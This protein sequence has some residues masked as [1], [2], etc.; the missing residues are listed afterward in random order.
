MKSPN[1]LSIENPRGFD[2]VVGEI[3]NALAYQEGA[4]GT[5]IKGLGWLE[6]VYGQARRWQKEDEKGRP[7]YFPKVYARKAE[8]EPLSFHDKYKGQ[9][10]FVLHDPQGFP[11]FTPGN[12]IL[13]YQFSIIFS[14]HLRKVNN[15]LDYPFEQILIAE[16]QKVISE[17][18]HLGDLQLLEVFSQDP[19]RVLEG[20]SVG[21]QELQLFMYPFASFRFRLQVDVPEHCIQDFNN[22]QFIPCN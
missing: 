20:F 11:R 22:H 16:A 1:I 15:Q 4:G 18:R 7:F 17:V 3:Q 6:L 2:K 14:V 5:R 12:S 8:F 19:A 9:C 21:K 10:F 13:R